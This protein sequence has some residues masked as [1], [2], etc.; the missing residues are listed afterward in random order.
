VTAFRLRSS[1]RGVLEHDA[2]D[3]LGDVG[4]ELRGHLVRARPDAGD[5]LHD[6]GASVT[7]PEAPFDGF[8][9]PRGDQCGIAFLG[10]GPVESAEKLPVAVHVIAEKRAQRR[11]LIVG[12]R[13][14][15]LPLARFS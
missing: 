13:H 3:P 10:L 7:G 4:I 8:G 1:T 12:Y 6:V 15:Y 5:E 14:G 9:E 11:H 2:D